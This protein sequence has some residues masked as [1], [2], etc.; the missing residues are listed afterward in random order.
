MLAEEKDGEVKSPAAPWWP[1]K[2]GSGRRQASGALGQAFLSAEWN[3][4]SGAPAMACGSGTRGGRGAALALLSLPRWPELSEPG[5]S[6][7][8]LPMPGRITLSSNFPGL[9]SRA[10]SVPG[11]T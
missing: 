11:Q 3:P 9:N 2:E 7:M 1:R 10:S 6:C 5:P 8:P 4:S